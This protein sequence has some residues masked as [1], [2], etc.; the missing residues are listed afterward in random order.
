MAFNKVI[1]VGNLVSDPELK[2][3]P[4][5]VPVCSFTIAVNRRFAKAGEQQQT[6]FINIVSWRQNAEFVS[7]YVQKGKAILICG[8]LQTRSWTANDGSK[9]YATEV[10]ADEATFVEKKGEASTF[11][12]RGDDFQ[13]P[14]FASDA[15]IAPKFEEVDGDE[16]LPF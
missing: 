5:G 14:S 12:P 2:Q 16:D 13:A 4:T 9:R 10:V 6:D 11:A 8:S 1:L 15:G 7:K 3:T